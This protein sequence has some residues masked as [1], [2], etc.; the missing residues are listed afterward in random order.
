MEIL[1]Q[2]SP[3]R[4]TVPALRWPNLSS[5]HL[6]RLLLIV[7]DRGDLPLTG[8]SADDL[9]LQIALREGVGR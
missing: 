6:V 1:A 5:R 9:R 4:T 3:Q 7:Y 2:E 8:P